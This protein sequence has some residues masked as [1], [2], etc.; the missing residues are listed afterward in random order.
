M[1]K[2]TF[3]TTSD[4]LYSQSKSPSPLAHRKSGV[5]AA[6]NAEAYILKIQNQPVV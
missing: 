3:N 4:D 1:I 2:A 5:A 6:N